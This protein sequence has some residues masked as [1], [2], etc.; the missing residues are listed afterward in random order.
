MNVIIFGPPG[1]GKGTQASNISKKFKLFKISTG[2]LL[3][4]EIK[5]NSSIGIKIKSIIDQGHFVSDNIINDLVEKILLNKKY[6]NKI[7]FDGYP[8]NLNQAK[9]LDSLMMSYKQKISCAINLNVNEDIIV[10]RIL[11]RSIC[12]KC[13]L[14]FNKYFN[15]PENSNHKC[16][17]DYLNTR[18]DDNEETIKSRFEVY[19]K[20]TLPMLNHYGSQK[21]LRHIDGMRKI[22]QIN[23]EICDII[24]SLE[25]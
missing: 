16:G 4:N 24:A 1:A 13:G 6:I 9:K 22:E 5:D 18:S 3:R 20:E 2:D 17:S 15:P 23:E 7:I 12:S 25:A 8:R 14:T 19:N 11:G 10:K 21:L